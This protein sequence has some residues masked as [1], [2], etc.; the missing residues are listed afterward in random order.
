MYGI[1]GCMGCMGFMNG[2]DVMYDINVLKGLHKVQSNVQSYVCT[3]H[4]KKA[5]ILYAVHT[6]CTCNA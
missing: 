6:Y 4:V 1:D 5:N 3:S 2:W